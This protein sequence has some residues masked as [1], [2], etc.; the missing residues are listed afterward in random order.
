MAMTMVLNVV[1]LFLAVPWVG[2]QFMIVVFPDYTHLIFHCCTD[3]SKVNDH[4]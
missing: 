3:I 2:L 4:G 1:C